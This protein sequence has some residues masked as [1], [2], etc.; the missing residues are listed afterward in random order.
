MEQVTADLHRIGWDE[1]RLRTQLLQH[2]AGVLALAARQKDDEE[3]SVA[4]RLSERIASP[5]PS[6]SGSAGR[7]EGAHFFAGN[8]EALD[9][10]GR[11]SPGGG[12][13]ALGGATFSSLPPDTAREREL[14]AQLNEVQTQLAQSQA[15]LGHR[16]REASGGE[17]AR[18]RM[19]EEVSRLEMEAAAARKAEFTARDEAKASRRDAMDARQELIGLRKDLS[20]ARDVVA[21]RRLTAVDP[22]QT[23]ELSRH[24]DQARQDRTVLE[25]KLE[26]AESRASEAE[27]GL[28]RE[29]EGR[30]TEVDGLRDE[31]TA[32]RSGGQE[33]ALQAKVNSL[34]EERSRLTQSVGDVLRRHRTRAATGAVLREVHAFDDTSEHDDLAQ[35]V[36]TSLDS[37]FDRLSTHVAAISAELETAH[38]GFATSQSTAEGHLKA[39]QHLE[40]EHTQLKRDLASK[41]GSAAA[42]EQSLNMAGQELAAAQQKAQAAET[43]VND[44]GRQLKPL[45]ELWK[46]IPPIDSRQAASGADDLTVLKHAFEPPK[47]RPL[48]NF[49]ADIGAKADSA[50]GFTTEALAERIRQLLGE[51]TKLVNKLI[52]F[53]AEKDLHRIAATKAS[54]QAAEASLSATE[55]T[56]R[57]KE[58]EERI[59]VSSQQEVTMLERLND[60][61]ESLEGTRLDKRKAE[62]QLGLVQ[63]QQAKVQA[64]HD[65]LKAELQSA[66]TEVARL[67]TKPDDSARISKLE[68]QI[69]EL[70]DENDDLQHELEDLK[71]RESKQRSQLLAELSDAQNESAALRT[72]LR[73]AERKAGGK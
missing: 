27:A 24:L 65:A 54:K 35:Y 47:S 60:L 40:A 8:R 23:A 62:T 5:S 22:E 15:D 41:S 49:L 32:A 36:S 19:E 30:S 26:E 28:E 21:S 50:K 12:S 59:E 51:D 1:A 44:F 53:E 57:V 18:L 39:K 37:H 55:A 3:R 13:P 46:Q 2:T 9:P 72:K 14:E 11:F 17:A 42:L 34:T 25:R 70:R 4:Q 10:Q 61:T 68:S 52:A 7:F 71:Q 33:E 16:Q 58:M 45:Q 38:N 63:T 56:R 67:A 20:T 48:G 64:D 73:Q 6:G 66:K 31:L 69:Q 43:Q 29:R